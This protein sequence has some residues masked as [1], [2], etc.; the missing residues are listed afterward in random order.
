MAV[1]PID[2]HDTLLRMRHRHIIPIL[3][4]T[5]FPNSR[6]LGRW[7]E[8]VRTNS[9]QR[10]VQSAATLPIRRAVFTHGRTRN[11]M[12]CLRRPHLG[13]D[14]GDSRPTGILERGTH[15]LLGGCWLCSSF[16]YWVRRQRIATI[17][18]LG[19]LSSAVL[20]IVLAARGLIL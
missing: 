3:Q 10:W 4:Q 12:Q 13:R 11:R 15:G 6:H 2:T 14:F 20:F 8:P 17:M 19:A 7:H 16:L 1:V 5:Q 18:N 9:L